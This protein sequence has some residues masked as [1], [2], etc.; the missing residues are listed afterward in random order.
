LRVLV[1]GGAGAIGSHVVDALLARG[2]DVAV[3]DSFHDFYPRAR[4]ERNLLAARA[5]PGFAGVLEGDIR[6]PGFVA[7]CFSEFAPEAC[8][9]LAARA[10][11]G[12]SL[13]DPVGYADV[14]LL[15]TSVVLNAAA[16]AGVE[17]FVFASSS[18][19]YGERPRGAFTEDMPTDRPLSPYAATKRGGELLCHAANAATGLPITCL[20]FFT[21]YGPRQRPDL[22]IHTFA[23]RILDGKPIPLF[24][25]GSFERDFTYVSDTVDGIVRALDRVDGYAIFNLG[26]GKPVTMNE[27]IAAL[28]RACGR[29]A[30]I[31]RLPEMAGNVPRTWA[32][33]ER[34]RTVLGY[35]P[36]IDLEPGI[37]SF[38][39]WLRKEDACASS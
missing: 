5:N 17:R 11:V 32:S 31:E 8:V 1:T 23:R 24:G 26:R 15:G 35:E 38:I 27:T 19:V 25:D 22:S 39:T 36:R 7:R 10:G 3:L 34:A 20:R 4:K 2:D 30:E 37:A 29:R 12:P 18:S 6:T 16:A 33:I 9:H 28:E 13:A 14:N 21:V